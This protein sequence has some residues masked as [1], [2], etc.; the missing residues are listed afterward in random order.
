MCF[1]TGW[2]FKT[3]THHTNSAEKEHTQLWQKPS[4]TRE[5]T[6]HYN[7]TPSNAPATEAFSRSLTAFQGV[8]GRCSLS[9]KGRCNSRPLRASYYSYTT[10]DAADNVQYEKRTLQTPY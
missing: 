9:V 2:H 1:K 3:V 6:P 8:L 10:L 5:P 4:Q 7:S